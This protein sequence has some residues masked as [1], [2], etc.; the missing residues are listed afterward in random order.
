[1][2]LPR[3]DYYEKELRFSVSCSYGPGRYD[4]TYEEAGL[5]YPAGFVRWTEGR[6]LEAVLDLMAAGAFDPLPLVTHRFAVRRRAPRLRHDRRPQRTVLRHPA[7]LSRI[8]RRRRRAR[9]RWRRARASRAGSGSASRA[10]GRSPRRS[11]CRRSVTT[12]RTRLEAIFTRTGLTAADVGKRNGFAVAV[13][14]PEAVIDHAGTDALV[15]AT[16]HD[17]HGPLALAA[18]QAGKHVFVEKPLCLTRDELRSI[19]RQVDDHGRGRHAAAAA[20]R[21]QPPLLAGGARPAQALRRQSRPPDHDV[22][23]QRRTHPAQ[24]LDPGSRSPAAAASWA[25]S[26]TSST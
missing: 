1:M 17:Q 4:P 19:T 5:D 24:P 9:S 18:L 16:R 25:R 2:D 3:K 20:G 7:A 21:L 15:I 22:P 10:P 14:T 8:R 13:D 23:D 6:N 11:C 26:A 12:A